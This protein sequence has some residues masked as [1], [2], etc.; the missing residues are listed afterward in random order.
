MT[1][2]PDWKRLLRKAWSLRLMLLAAVLSGVEVA[3]PFFSSAVPPGMFAAAS[4]V[5]VAAAFVARLTAQK[6]LEQRQDGD[7]RAR[8]RP[9]PDYKAADY[10]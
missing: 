3:L 9:N 4:F 10:D 6:S 1:L 8:H 5:V 2:L 7:R